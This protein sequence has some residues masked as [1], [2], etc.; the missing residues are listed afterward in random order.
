MSM[1]LR[2]PEILDLIRASGHVEVEELATRF[3]VSVQTIRRDLSDLAEMGRIERVHGGAI[4]A[5]G[6][7][8]IA[9]D[10]RR[11]L[12]SDAKSII[13]E[14]CAQ[15]IPNECSVFLN[16]GTTTEAVARRLQNHKGLLVVTNNMNIATVLGDAPEVDVIVTGGALRPAMV[17]W[18]VR[19]QI[20]RLGSLNSI[21]QLL[22]ALR[23]VKKASCLILTIKRLRQVA[24]S[25]NPRG[26]RYWLQMGQNFCAQRRSRLL[27]YRQLIISSP[28]L[29]LI[30]VCGTCWKHQRQLC[31]SRV[32][33]RANNGY[34][35]TH[36]F[37]DFL[38]MLRAQFWFRKR[39]TH[40][41]FCCSK[42]AKCNYG[43]CSELYR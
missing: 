16:I 5:S 24:S 15:M 41:Y 14:Y 23:W 38:V 43:A 10:E 27:M 19:L 13:A 36:L 28:T 4:L 8:N 17:V 30:S 39:T 12:N 3:G 31:I 32:R 25:C 22:V 42:F 35:D 37:I 29:T 40:H 26:H 20:K 21:T 7:V 6:T 33:N 11:S 9:Y 18:L 1:S 2:H 34:W